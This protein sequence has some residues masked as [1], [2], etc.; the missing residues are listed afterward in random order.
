VCVCVC[1]SERVSERECASNHQA[2]H[3]YPLKYT[4]LLGRRGI[5]YALS[6]LE[7]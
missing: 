1:V 2:I 3:K 4:A 7:I 5:T 6:G